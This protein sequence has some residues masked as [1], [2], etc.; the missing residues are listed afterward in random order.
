MTGDAGHRTYGG[1]RRSRGMGLFGLGTGATVAIL[2]ALTV[3]VIATSVRPSALLLA[4]PVCAAV[5][6][7]VVVRWDGVTLGQ[8]LRQR[9]RWAAAGG[10]TDYRGG[11]CA[12]HRYGWHLPGVLAATVLLSADDGRGGTYGVVWNRRLGTMTVTLRCAAQSTWLADPAQA[13][14]W[15]ANWG[16]WLAG[17][18]HQP[19]VRW[20]AVTVDTAPDS[21]SRLADHVA[22]RL[23]PDSP[24]AARRILTRL[25][26]ASPA[27]SADVQTWVSITFDPYASPARPRDVDDAV[28]QVGRALPG[29]QDALAG[30]GVTVL[31]RATAAE[32][33]GVVRGAF[34]PAYRGD[35]ARLLTPSP[36]RDDT[37]LG[38]DNAG[39]VAATEHRDRYVHDGAVS[40][41][42][43]WHEAPRQPV[44]HDILARLVCPG[45]YPMRVTLL[46]RPL[47]AAHAAR[48]V[49]DQV[50]AAQFREAYRR[51]RKLDPRARDVADHQQALQAAREEAMG[52]GVGFLSL[53]T[54]V[55]VLDDTDLPAAVAD[56]ESRAETAKIRLR[57]L[58]ASQAAGFATTLPCGICPPVL[59]EHW[60]H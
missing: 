42:W 7:A 55:T 10:R 41:S 30:C 3:T 9:A 47:P 22:A 53:F 37:L 26:A 52:A 56:V 45:S 48:V 34:D 59:A 33:A 28:A 40:V 4:G 46:Y 44:H 14:V 2:A 60:P 16:G 35:L 39:P 25:V 20:V 15:V 32:L 50:N 21:G 29:L 8:A 58:W 49:E 51:S 57:R 27:A 24:A 17:L 23:A 38:W 13:G 11:V 6:A 31:G 5:T 43:A 12:P 36:Q 18:G 54:T 1:W 19:L